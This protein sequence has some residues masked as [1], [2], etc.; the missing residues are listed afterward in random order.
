MWLS[1]L[2]QELITNLP[3]PRKEIDM[4]SIEGCHYRTGQL[5]NVSVEADRI[6]DVRIF[7]QGPSD[8]WIGPGLVDAQVN[9]YRGI[10]F[11]ANPLTHSN[12][13]QVVAELWKD[14]VTTFMPTII[15][16]ST[17]GNGRLQPKL[18]RAP[19]EFAAI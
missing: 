10:D 16:T 17:R 19:G 6:A 1:R 7:G 14:G 8:W 3:L 12:L 5:I 11:N 15:T 13:E 18:D 4:L 9:G 2:P